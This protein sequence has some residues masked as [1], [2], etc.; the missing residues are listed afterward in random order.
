VRGDG[1]VRCQRIPAKSQMRLL[2]F[3]METFF[4]F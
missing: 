3:V 1:N 4:L 2:K